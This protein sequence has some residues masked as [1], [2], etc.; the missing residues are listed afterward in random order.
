MATSEPLLPSHDATPSTVRAYFARVLCDRHDVPREE[1]ENI[2]AKWRYG[3]G[4]EVA[5]YDVDTFR[6]IFGGEAGN[7]L[8]GYARK[9][10]RTSG[11]SPSSRLGRG[12]VVGK[13]RKDIFG[14]TPGLSIVYLF[15][16]LSILFGFR[17]WFEMNKENTDRVLGLG[18]ICGCC[19]L[20][21]LFSYTVYYFPLR[22]QRH[23]V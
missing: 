4:S 22:P 21:F 3:R 19:F 18:T 6:S 2:A 7:L 20:G 5:Y 11:A 17:V 8:F 10:L 13:C 12:E 1:A 14:M 9:E 16:G 23:N 15:F